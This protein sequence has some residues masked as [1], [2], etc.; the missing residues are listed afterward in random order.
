LRFTLISDE[1]PAVGL[2][3]PKRN[4]AE[5]MEDTFGQEGSF[6]SLTPFLEW[7]EAEPAPSSH[8]PPHQ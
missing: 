6:D 1:Y 2:W 8:P 4:A 7:S 3:P 5:L